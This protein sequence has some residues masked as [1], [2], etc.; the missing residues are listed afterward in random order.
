MSDANRVDYR[1]EAG[2]TPA[3]EVP[4]DLT[5]LARDGRYRPQG[6]GVV[7]ASGAAAAVT[8][9]TTILT[10]DVYAPV[11][12]AVRRCDTNKDGRI[13]EAEARIFDSSVH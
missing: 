11:N 3:L 4:P 7:T 10:V 2:K 8:S 13:T 5:Q 12:K 6:G 9:A 1:S